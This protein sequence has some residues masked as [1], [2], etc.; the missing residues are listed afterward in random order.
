MKT[1]EFHPE[2]INRC[3]EFVKNHLEESDDIDIRYY[4]PAGVPSLVALPQGITKPNIL[5]NAHLDVVSLAEEVPYRSF[6]KDGKIIGPGV[7]DMKGELAI[8]LEVFRNIHAEI[9]DASLGIAITSD[10]E[11]G[12]EHGIKYLFEKE[13]VRC[14]LAIIPDSGSLNEITIEEKGV[15]HMVISAEGEAGHA[16]RP[17]MVENPLERISDSIYQIRSC[18]KQME[19]DNDNWH[20]TFATTII[21]TDNEAINRI[22][23]KAEAHCDIRFPSPHTVDSVLSIIKSH[24][25]ED[26]SLKLIV[27]S[28]PSHL[29]PDPLFVQITEEI[30]GKPT[31]FFRAHGGSDA[32]FISSLD[33][34]VIMSRPIVGDTH[35]VHEWIDID[36]METLYHIYMKYLR[37]KLFKGDATL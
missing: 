5:L 12:G 22:P 35:S 28:N 26:M 25:D 11:R 3:I 4:S 36:S 9:P 13:G 7:G 23:E 15:I 8:L 32:R 21:H 14:N 31:T 16:S 27:S 37:K 24:L 33:I 19:S 20:P 34:P 18:F 1:T 17:W 30:T 10:E 2:E 6:V 29:S